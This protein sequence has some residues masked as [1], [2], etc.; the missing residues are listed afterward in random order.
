MHPLHLS[1]GKGNLEQSQKDNLKGL[2]SGRPVS[3]AAL[4][5]GDPAGWLQDGGGFQNAPVSGATP[6]QPVGRAQAQIHSDVS[7]VSSPVPLHPK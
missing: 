3:S 4:A 7:R 1:S 6:L 2:S 5:Q